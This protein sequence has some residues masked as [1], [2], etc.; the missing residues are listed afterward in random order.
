METDC[1]KHTRFLW[2]IKWRLE[3]MGALGFVGEAAPF[4][5]G[6]SQCDIKGEGEGRERTSLSRLKIG[7][8]FL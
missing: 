5:F 1:S 8:L 4:A 3:H 7:L 2:K 6:R